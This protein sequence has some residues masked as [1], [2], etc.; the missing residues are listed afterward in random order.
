MRELLS[1]EKN[2]FFILNGYAAG[3]SAQSFAQLTEQVFPD[4]KS[5]FGELCIQES[6]GGRVLPSGIYTRF[7]R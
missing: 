5:D 4:A 2:S 1:E 3:Y 7:Q 6:N